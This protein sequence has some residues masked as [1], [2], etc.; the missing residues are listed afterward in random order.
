M[1]NTH[2]LLYDKQR[3]SQHGQ[4]KWRRF[5]AYLLCAVAIVM[6]GCDTDQKKED[7][8]QGYI[9]FQ[10]SVNSMFRTAEGAEVPLDPSLVPA[11]ESLSVTLSDAAGKTYTWKTL[12]DFRASDESFMSGEYTAVIEGSTEDGPR[13]SSTVSF[14]L[15]P[16]EHTRVT[17]EA[18]PVQAMLRI[19]RQNRGAGRYDLKGLTLFVPLR[20]FISIDEATTTIFTHAGEMQTFAL[21]ADNTGG[22]EALVA[23]DA[24]CMLQTGRIADVSVTA[25]NNELAVCTDI[26]GSKSSLSLKDG[27]PQGSAPTVTAGGYTPGQALTVTEGL[28]LP[29]PVTMTVTS[30]AAPL[31]HVYVTLESPVV[32]IADVPFSSSDIMNLTA[33]EEQYLHEK[34]FEFTI[35]DNRRQVTINYTKVIEGMASVSS[36]TSTY[37]L[38]AVNSLGN[39]SEPHRLIVNTRVMSLSLQSVTPA[40]IGIDR[41]VITLASGSEH[42]EA[43]DF[44]FYA[45]DASGNFTV[46]CPVISSKRLPQ[47]DIS[48]EIS[49]PEGTEGLDV[50]VFYLGLQRLTCR[51]ARANPGFSIS[52][53]AFATTAILLFKSPLG[54]EVSQTVTRLA[55]I[56]VDGQPASVWV[57]EPERSAVVI[58][59]LSPSHT[60][61]VTVSLISGINA[62]RAQIRTESA[63]ELPTADFMDWK[64]IVEYN[65]LP[66]RGRF[67]A[68]PVPIVNR[69]NYTDIRINWPKKTWASLNAKT[70]CTASR[71]HNT[72]Y[73]E[74]SAW[75][76]DR[77]DDGVKTMCIMSVG[78]D[79]DGEEIAD[80]IQQP[81][82]ITD[83]SLS[84]PRVSRRS[85]GR[86][87]M[88]SYDY[89]PVTD[90]ETIREGVP[91]T[92]RPSA[93]NGMY[94]YIPDLTDAGDLGTV[95]I[96]LV[97]CESDG[98]ETVIASG[99]QEFRTS[100]DYTAF[101]VP[102]SY[103]L[104]NVRPTHLRLMFCSS[105][106]AGGKGR[107]ADAQV[108]VTADPKNGMMKGSTLWVTSLSFTY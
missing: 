53:D 56:Y 31:K 98:S 88:G 108:P 43:G 94:K 45:A 79:H 30:G 16:G 3:L 63:P 78:Y 51:V 28:T 47:N 69:Q 97:R 37:T 84:V 50:A 1:S 42:T 100:S 93:L 36:S 92:S 61:A 65:H 71:N 106:R 57:R 46:P 39:C 60:Y 4:L 32:H 18:V 52:A 86:L 10:V 99:Q 14:M 67:S 87:W 80:Y 64:T 5:L 68:T 70:F 34:G 24:P 58:N 8:H 38:M 62:G 96:R 76:E 95:D 85:A 35:S 15:N 72:W 89:D 49:V 82:M 26:D 55:K 103:R 20:G 77:T 107:D 11:P 105:N 23:L 73:M 101:N 75:L 29:E 90:T 7:A 83:Y 17:V 91:F 13:F 22:E 81:G 27:L 21:L 6:Q 12:D 2:T 33:A 54:A 59:G 19:S 102:L 41:S 66:Q 9:D 104:F 40:T 48:F 44:A 74:P 25:D